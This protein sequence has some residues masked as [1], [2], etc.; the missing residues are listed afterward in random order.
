[1]GTIFRLSVVLI[2]IV[3][4]F[5]DQILDVIDRILVP[6]GLQGPNED[7][8]TW[9]SVHP[10]LVAEFGPWI[11]IGGGLF[12]L[13]MMD[14]LRPI[15]LKLRGAAL[16]ILY[17]SNDERFAREEW[18][19][20]PAVERTTHCSVG[21]RN[22]MQVH[23]LTNVAISVDRNSFVDEIIVPCWGNKHTVHLEKLDPGA[24]EY[25]ELCVLTDNVRSDKSGALLGKVHRFT[26]RTKA[27]GAKEAVAEFE[28]DPR[29]TPMIRRRSRIR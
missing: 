13:L 14:I 17:D 16:E 11:L 9:F 18:R 21:I 26:I 6:M 2:G 4:G 25:I 19:T 3:W 29:A 22:P 15:F 24:T 5:S 20:N 12:S 1:M 27:K 23:S 28:Y 7:L 10:N 8:R